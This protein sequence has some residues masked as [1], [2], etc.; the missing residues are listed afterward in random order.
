M[1][2]EE[3]V[4]FNFDISRLDWYKSYSGFAFGIRKFAIKEDVPSPEL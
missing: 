4:E 3:K 1:T 2:P